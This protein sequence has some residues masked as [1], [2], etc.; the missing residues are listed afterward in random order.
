MMRKRRILILILGIMLVFAITAC[1]G[2]DVSDEGNNEIVLPE[3]STPNE[4]GS[5]DG[6]KQ[7][8]TVGL[9]GVTY[10]QDY[11]KENELTL[12]NVWGTYCGPCIEEMPY[13]GEL[14]RDYEESGFRI[15][16]LVI[17]VQGSDYSIDES[18][19]KEA[20]SIVQETDA[21]YLHLLL[22]A[23]LSK[24]VLEGY[25]VTAIPTSFFVDSEGNVVGEPIVGSLSKSEWE[26][27]I[28]E[29]YAQVQ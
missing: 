8:E 18:M 19:A 25:D 7:F 22:S 26:T 4:S 29:M 17:D 2:D 1:S 14:S 23:N 13:L 5:A 27:V 24:G 28:E 20:I 11:F 3:W 12:V 10:N 6:F 16:G 15:I 9:D 21:T